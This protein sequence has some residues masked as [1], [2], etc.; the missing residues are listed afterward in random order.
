[1]PILGGPIREPPR[2]I[3]FDI[4]RVIISVNLARSFETF[5]QRDGPSTEQVWK[6]L[7]TDSRWADWQEGRMTPRDWHKHLCNK[8]R[9]S[10]DFEEFCEN[11]NRVLEPA[12]IL[13]EAL[14]ERLARS[15]RLALLSNTD[16]IHVAH[17]E[18]TF[19]FVRHFSVRVYSCRVGSSKPAPGIYHH[20]LRELDATPQ[21]TLY[22]DDIRE[23]AA[24]AAHLGMV[25]FHFISPEDLLSEFTRLDLWVP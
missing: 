9:L 20:A 24:V 4:G 7:E 12:P 11:W 1:V 8:L 22:I 3:I 2:A 17:I 23:N 21:E 10:L 5:G 14:F 25:G 19:P 18:A 13:P 16:P 15:C 6:A